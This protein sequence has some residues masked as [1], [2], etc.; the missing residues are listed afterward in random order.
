[1]LGEHFSYDVDFHRKNIKYST[2]KYKWNSILNEVN[3]SLTVV[4]LN[5]TSNYVLQ[6]RD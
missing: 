1:M 3:R 5:P 6:F 2:S 4:I